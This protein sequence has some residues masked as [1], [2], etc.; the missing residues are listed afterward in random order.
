[1]EE[2]QIYQASQEKW[3][4]AGGYGSNP[5]SGLLLARPRTIDSPGL[6]LA[7][8]AIA[9]ASGSMC[10]AATKMDV[11]GRLADRTVI[12]AL[13]WEARQPIAI[14]VVVSHGLIVV[15]RG[16]TDSITSQGNLRLPALV[17]RALALEGGQQLLLVGVPQRD[18]V[19]A[20]TMG[21]VHRML[22]T[23]HQNIMGETGYG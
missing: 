9:P 15:R 1:V 18:A 5:R 2:F 22:C 19:I 12:R 11:H 21:A 10:V 16:G 6:P 17:R 3:L 23:Y 4:P 7:S 8:L 13:R 14:A 20:Y